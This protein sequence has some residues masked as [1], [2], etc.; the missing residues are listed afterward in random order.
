MT[1]S[2]VGTAEAFD[3]EAK[4][5][6]I[7]GPVLLT[8][9]QALVRLLLDQVRAD[10][11]RGLRTAAFVS[12]YPGSPL[13]GFDLALGRAGPL[14]AEHD[15]TFVPG[16]N[17]D[18]AATAVWGSQ[19]DHLAPLARHDGVIGLWYG[20]SPGVDRCGDVLRQ[21]NLHGVG[22]NG[23]VVVA[24]GDDPTSKSSTLPSQSELA[25]YDAMIPVLVP[26]DVQEV[27]DLGRHAFEL[28]RYSGCWAALKIVTAVADGF[29]T[30]LVGPDRPRVV[31]PELRIDGEVYRHVQARRFF[32]PETLELERD[33]YYRRHEAVKAYAAA[34]GLNELA[35]D[36]EGAWLGIV[37]SGRTY[38]ELVEA[39]GRLGLDRAGLERAG[40]R[41]L[42]VGMIFP[43]EDTI[44]R[45][46]ARGLEEVLV[47]EEKRGLLEPA[48]REILYGPSAPRL[49]GKRDEHGARL[50]PADGELTAERLEPLL[51][52]RLTGRVEL[53]PPA[54]RARAASRRTLPVRRAH[55]CSGCPHNRST[56]SASGSPVGAGI[57]CHAMVLWMDRGVTTYT[58]MGGEGAQWIGRAPFTDVGHLVQNVGD[59]TF[60]HSG[61]LALRAAV[62]A[63]VRITFKLLYNGVIAMTGGQDPPGQMSVPQLCRLLQAEGVSRIA[64][65]SDE[66][67]RYRRRSRRLPKGV[68]LAGRE[69]LAEV[70]ASLARAP[71]VSVLV[72]DQACAAELRRLRR[73]G[74]APERPRRVV[75]NEAVCEGCGDCG[76]KSGCLSVHP[77]ETELGRKTRIHQ[78]SCN[79]DYSC[80]EGDCPSF[81]TLRAPRRQS[82]PPAPRPVDVSGL[83]APT[84]PEVGEDGYDVFLAGVGGTGVVTVNQVLATAAHLAGLQVRGLDQTGL[85]QKG[86]PVVSHLRLRRSDAP[87]SS[88]VGPGRA[89]CYLALDLV[90]AVDAANLARADPGRTLVVASTSVAPT[91][92]MV[93]GAT[94][95]L[96]STRHL[97][98]ALAPLAR[99]LVALDAEALALERTGDHLTANMAVLGAAFQAG[100]LPVP[101]ELLERAIELNG[102]AVA[103]NL[104]AFRAG[105]RAAAGLEP[106]APQAPAAPEGRRARRARELVAARALAGEVVPFVERR[107][108]D[109]LE[110]SGERL[111]RRYLDLLER[112]QRR[113]AD[114]DP[115]ARRLTATVAREAYRLLAYKD[116]YEV[117]RLYLQGSFAASLDGARSVRYLLHPPL[118][119]SLGLRRK[120]ALPAFVAR[121]AF[122]VLH[123][124]RHL[125]GTPFDPF[126]HT[127][128]RRAERALV[129]EYEELVDLALARLDASTYSACVRLVAAPSIVRGYEGVKL[130]SLE[131]YRA[132]VAAARAALERAG[133]R[134]A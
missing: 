29:G 89:D 106:A 129:G 121:P 114:V 128:V 67:S 107:V 23:G 119:R 120:V 50:V 109:L 118:L 49:V 30:A 44:V 8:G 104:A 95:D 88:A 59:G 46:F 100:G 11:R 134:P 9:T 97:L 108:A 113:E 87:G 110:R 56:L 69:R 98:D 1:T 84:L 123:A 45:R 13:G 18:L 42:R 79:T 130:A 82:S 91:A 86:G 38:H 4:Y 103:A 52:S 3:L 116:E 32:V 63:G 76:A 54:V 2:V 5:R 48:L 94:A 101:A 124:L 93:T 28:S 19:Q 117:A 40:V 72:Y 70:E 17:E 73:R 51:R 92:D 80:L 102:V 65:V 57:G 20:K 47:V 71:G 55:F 14:L 25:F 24:A 21:A 90:V 125:R 36:P 62:A 61:S 60:F 15:V 64:V 34:N 99:Q 122:R 131:R 96:P 74:R 12:G 68:E 31:H 10:R 112:V 132:E 77:V 39:L 127:V 7:E 43:L 27:L 111:A 33:L 81:V 41:L 133:A 58:H 75:I 66:P 35:T 85:A 16:L 22:R 115:T 26:G 126:G 105:R 37:A 83:A 6:A 53:R 78:P